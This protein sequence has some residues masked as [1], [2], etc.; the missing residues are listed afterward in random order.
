MLTREVEPKLLGGAVVSLDHK[1]ID[2]TIATELWRVRQQL[3]Q[4]RVQARG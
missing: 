3:L 1:V 4:A 2:G